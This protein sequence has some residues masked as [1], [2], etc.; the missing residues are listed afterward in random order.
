[1]NIVNAIENLIKNPII[2]LVEY[3]QGK[4]R[5]NNAGNSLEEYM[6]DLFANSFNLSE[7]E[8]NQK[9]SQVFS[10]LGNT[11]NPPDAMLYNGEAIEVKKIENYNSPLALNS[12]YPKQK[13]NK[14]NPL[15]SKACLNAED[16]YEKDIIYFVGVVQ[17]NI[18][19]R[20]AIIYGVD[21][22]ASDACYER[23]R[24]TIKNGV[25]NID[26]VIF[27]KT[28]ELGRVNRIDPLGIT[29]L[30]VRG[31]WG[32]ENPWNVFHYVY[33]AKNNFNFMCLINNDKWN[34]L[35]D[36]ERLLDLEKI[37]K[38]FQISDVNIKNPDNP[39]QLRFAKLLSYYL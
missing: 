30:R 35:Q 24:D 9:L 16:W 38:R 39:A 19:R 6:K 31:M 28:K 37:E 25:E 33:Q 8:R 2:E 20:L 13:L 14:N 3:Y 1:M 27:S 5:I 26:G 4:N 23:I 36:K 34:A 10:Y 29:Y 32:I 22:C 18:L 11:N 7:I 12:S 17:N 21:Y 15:I